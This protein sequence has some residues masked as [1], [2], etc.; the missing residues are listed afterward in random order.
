[1][2]QVGSIIDTIR[3]LEEGTLTQWPLCKHPR[4]YCDQMGDAYIRTHALDR[5]IS[6][7][8]LIQLQFDRSAQFYQPIS[9]FYQTLTDEQKRALPVNID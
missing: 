3:H 9:D 8:T 6:E 5:I 4:I 2:K 7:T 1:M